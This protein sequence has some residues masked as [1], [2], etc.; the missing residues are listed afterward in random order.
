MASRE[1]ETFFDPISP[2]DPFA[3]RQS[4]GTEFF[5]AVY[6]DSADGVSV[7]GETKPLRVKKKGSAARIA[8]IGPSSKS[9]Y[10]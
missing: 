9:A 2:I 8:G 1:S 5:K 3:P 4:T 7:K 6:L 10:T